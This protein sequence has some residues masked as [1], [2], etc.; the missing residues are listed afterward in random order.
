MRRAALLALGAGTVAAAWTAYSAGLRLGEQAAAGRAETHTR[1]LLGLDAW[2]DAFLADVRR[3]ERT[4]GAADERRRGVARELG[5]ANARVVLLEALA[6]RLVDD[7]D[8]DG[9]EFDFDAP[10]SLGGP[11]QVRPLDGA[12]ARGVR[13]QTA[14]V[15]AAL[16]RVPARIDDEWRE[17][18]V[19]ERV[20][21]S[22]SLAQ[23]VLPKGRPVSP[24]YVSSSFGER[25]D[26]FTGRT[27]VHEGVDF[28]GPRGA[29]V[30]AVAP[31]LVTWSGPRG[32]YGRMV[33]IDHGDLVTRYAHNSENVVAVGD[34]VERGQ[35]IARLGA[36]GRATG[37][38]LHF[39]VLRDGRA[40][41]PL[42]FT[43]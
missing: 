27:A 37:P 33:E 3:L 29:P 16:G 42:E 23:R 14:A 15:D 31:G 1:V 41:N 11:E 18:H 10:P 38:N 21:E 32:G 34:L 40:V 24:A 6:G 39:E 7:S 25:V 30:V 28:A 17:L 43:E 4:R 22:R 12:Q 36:T 19:L 9:Q 5:R 35:V 13:G 8:L 26:P 2:R 20:L